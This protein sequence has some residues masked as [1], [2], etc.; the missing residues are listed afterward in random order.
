MRRFGSALLVVAALLVAA[1]S[2]G[3]AAAQDGGPSVLVRVAPLRRGSLPRF[4]TV[5]GQMEADPTARRT[6]TAPTA[7]VVDSVD[8]RPG[9][10][11]AAGAPLLRLA[12]SPAT[13]AAYAQALAALRVA[14]DLVGR[15]RALL[16][17]HFATAQELA[18]AEKSRSDARATLA[19]LDAEGAGGPQLLRAPFA[20]VVS[21]ILTSPGAIVAE[22]AVLAELSRSG[23]VV[24]LA[25]AVPAAAA[26]IRPGDLAIITP[27]GGDAEIPGG[28]T[29]TVLLRGA[30]V[31]PQTGL[32]PVII[33]PPDGPFLAGEMAEARI[34][35]GHIRG[36]LVPHAAILVNDEGAPYVVQ[37]KNRVAH[38]VPVHILGSG[39]DMDVVAGPLDPS[40][41]LVLDGNYQLE[42]GMRVRLSGPTSAA[43]R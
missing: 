32:V 31:D 8:V 16:G 23:G 6:I 22:A 2:V 38:I 24:L 40:A 18:A 13:A 9:Q 41:A 12:P 43:G 36:Y 27:L 37:A 7:A 26:A 14:E 30:V 5:Y 39:P 42:D 11:V 10:S 15:T 20:G 35:T 3:H 29:G 4:V 17:Q 33:T 28:G 1:T 34:V 25:G 19:A 21:A